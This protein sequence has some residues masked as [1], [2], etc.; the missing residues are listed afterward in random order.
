MLIKL[1]S[2]SRSRPSS[3]LTLNAIA[4]HGFNILDEFSTIDFPPMLIHRS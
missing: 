4:A 1:G 2:R 3:S